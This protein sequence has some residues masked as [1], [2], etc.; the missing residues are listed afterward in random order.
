MRMAKHG[1]AVRDSFAGQE[2]EQDEKDNALRHSGNI[3]YS[4]ENSLA[5]T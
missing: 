3:T 5:V 4:L 2:Q 1:S